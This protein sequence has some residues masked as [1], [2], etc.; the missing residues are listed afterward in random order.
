MILTKTYPAKNFTNVFDEL[1]S[2]F[3]STFDARSNSS[4]LVNINENEAGYSVEFNVPGRNKED[5]TINVDK[6]LLT[7]GYEKKN[8]TE[9]KEVK[10]IR[11][12]FSFNNFKRSFSLDD[13]INA[14]NIEAKYENGI[15]KVFL[16]KKEEVKVA[17]KQIT[18]Q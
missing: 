16:P 13:K 12:E 1:I 17:P 9:N 4:V 2:S 8:E 18:I 11:K 5:F 14:E 10:S 15:L 7:V 3:P 6:G